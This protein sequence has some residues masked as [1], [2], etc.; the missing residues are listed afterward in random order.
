MQQAYWMVESVGNAHFYNLSIVKCSF[1]Q[2]WG[3][4]QLKMRPPLNILEFYSCQCLNFIYNFYLLIKGLQLPVCQYSRS[5]RLIFEEP[6]ISGI[7]RLVGR[8]A[9]LKLEEKMSFVPDDKFYSIVSAPSLAAS[10]SE[11]RC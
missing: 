11:P 3:A 6:S 8:P 4:F 1:G 9:E 2:Y 7:D 5:W 10:T